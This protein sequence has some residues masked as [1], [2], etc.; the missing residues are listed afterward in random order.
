MAKRTVNQSISPK[1]KCERRPLA[2][3]SAKSPIHLHSFSHELSLNIGRISLGLRIK[4]GKSR[5]TVFCEPEDRAPFKVSSRA[6]RPL[7]KHNLKVEYQVRS[8]LDFL[9]AKPINAL[10][11]Y[12]ATIRCLGLIKYAQACNE[13]GLP[14][15]NGDNEHCGLLYQFILLN[16]K[17][18]EKPPTVNLETKETLDY[19]NVCWKPNVS[20]METI[21]LQCQHRFHCVCLVSWLAEHS[22]CPNCP[23]AISLS[24]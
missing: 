23:I 17:L 16:S 9:P 22:T 15:P 6:H 24:K 19:C 11:Q 20:S 18:L 3:K 4:N 2:K 12:K 1:G 7:I 13:A 10:S 5:Q 8:Q 14:V 21:L